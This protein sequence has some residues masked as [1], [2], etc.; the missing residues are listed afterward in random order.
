[1]NLDDEMMDLDNSFLDSGQV[2]NEEE[3]GASETRGEVEETIKNGIH[4]KE[5][6]FEV[7]K[8][9]N[10]EKYEFGREIERYRRKT[11]HETIE[12]DEEKINSER[13]TRKD[14]KL[15][16]ICFLKV[17]DKDGNSGTYEKAQK[18]DADAGKMRMSVFCVIFVK[19]IAVTKEM[20][21]RHDVMR[22]KVDDGRRNEKVN[23]E[24]K[25][26]SDN[27]TR[28]WNE[29]LWTG[30]VLSEVFKIVRDKV[31]VMDWES[32]RFLKWEL[33]RNVMTLKSANAFMTR[34]NYEE[35]KLIR[36]FTR[37]KMELDIG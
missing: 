11:M 18:L 9:E 34:L 30:G 14:G 31:R 24:T 21:R 37:M 16:E 10:E 28:D 29:R 2:D 19:L 35:L 17:G 1:M 22:F 5:T 27:G 15:T 3:D 36:K 23:L 7:E 4:T 12:H 33:V 20:M 25:F 32:W 6:D 8:H 13:I 26:W